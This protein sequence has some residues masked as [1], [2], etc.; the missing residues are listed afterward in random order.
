MN[1]NVFQEKDKTK[2]NQAIWLKEKGGITVKKTK[3]P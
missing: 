1:I 2:T 3:L